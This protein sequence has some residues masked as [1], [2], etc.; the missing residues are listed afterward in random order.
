MNNSIAVSVKGV[1]KNFSLPQERITSIKS[2][3]VNVFRKKNKNLEVQYALKNVSFDIKKGEFFGIVGRNG[4]GKSTLLKIISS[5]YKPDSGTVLVNGSLV[6]FIEL[7]VG[8]N[9]ELSGRENVYLNSALL[10]F[11]KKQ[12]DEMYDDIVEFAELGKFIDQKLKNYSSGMQVRL[13]FSVA[14]RANSDILILDEIL[15]VGDEAF[16]KKCYE[17]F[18]QLKNNNKTVILVTHSMENV[19]R[20]CDRALILDNGKVVTMGSV[21]RVTE[22]YTR[23]NAQASDPKAL[24]GKKSSKTNDF[25]DIKLVLK[26]GN[27][28]ITEAFYDGIEDRIINID[29]ELVIKKDI[30][31]KVFISLLIK[32]INGEVI[33][34]IATEDIQ[35]ETE[36]IGYLKR[37]DKIK[38]KSS[39]QNIFGEGSYYIAL[40][41]K[42]VD[43]AESYVESEDHAKFTVAGLGTNGFS[44][45]PD[46][47]I[48]LI[49]E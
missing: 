32:N 24:K 19:T 3:I 16:Q 26:N 23:Q 10:G 1:S 45:R 31:K 34:R 18:A 25:A 21:K 29:T 27:N 12:V 33:T 8:F 48:T 14:V 36:R 17:Y 40:S 4:S 43:R 15:A 20:F 42:S 49:K 44:L 6:P 46:N 28:K 9:P 35:G 22:E 11:S 47:K 5:I 39:I 41:L 13:A 2:G 38:I 7:G 37:G 30:S